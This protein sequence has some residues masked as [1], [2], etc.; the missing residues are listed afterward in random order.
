MQR[1]AEV[2]FGHVETNLGDHDDEDISLPLE[3]L[4]DGVLHGPL[5]LLLPIGREVADITKPAEDIG[6]EPRLELMESLSTIHFMTFSRFSE[7]FAFSQSS[8][9]FLAPMTLSK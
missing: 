9:Y 4:H 7:L 3:V 8:R 6:P 1:V 2:P 5:H